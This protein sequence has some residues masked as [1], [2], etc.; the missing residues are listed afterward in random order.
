VGYWAEAPLSRDQLMLFPSTLGDSIP[1]DH[2]VRL[3]YEVLSVQDWSAWERHYC[4][5]AGQPAIH[6]MIVAGAILYGMSQGIR[7]SR[8]LEY[9]CGNSMDFIWL[10][11]DRHID[12]STFCNFRTR[13]G[14]EL[15]DLFRQIGRVAMGM[16]LVRLNQLGLDGTYVRA[17]SS[18]HATASA[19][20]LRERLE[21][22]DQ[23]VEEM[24]VQAQKAD[25][26]DRDLFGE[27]STPNQLPAA[28]SDVK[29]RQAALQKA[30]AAAEAMDAKR[31]KGGEP[32]KKASKVPVADADSTILPNKE[33]GYAPNYLPVAAVDGHCGFIVDAD[34][35]GDHSEPGTVLPT[36]DRIEAN[37]EKVPGQVLADSNFATGGNL[38]ALEGRGIEPLMPVESGTGS[39]ENPANRA[40]PRQPVP[41][42][43][44]PKLPRRPQTKRLDR[45]A[46]VYDGSSDGYRCPM[47]HWMGFYQTKVKDRDT[48][49]S[50]VYRVYRCVS[51]VG[52]PLA[53]ACLTEGTTFR[54]VSRDQ[55]EEA[56]ER[57]A[58]RLRSET[59]RTTYARRSWI[60]ETPYAVIKGR[61]GFRQFL[62]RGLEKVRT[63]WSWA[64]TAYNLQKL[65]GI[66]R[67]LRASAMMNPG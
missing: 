29:R 11:E 32:P 4:G 43:D 2:P 3:F 18:R 5:V 14:G 21:S 59:G 27:E 60:A 48:C 31:S 37:F 55:H 1:E 39:E 9:A 40:D 28:L 45:S 54:T 61:W 8:R 50:S 56:R 57:V 51:C 36:V 10:V 63:E 24:F 62:L 47:G 12:H 7:S 15:K 41:E 34:V 19:K 6:P 22:L 30:L 25:E 53:G 26:Q 20:T 49:E 46:F 67:A 33:G 23:Q 16:G 65:V 17:N 64:C 66:L 44:W 58:A 38:T 13:F 42:C 52:C 35:A